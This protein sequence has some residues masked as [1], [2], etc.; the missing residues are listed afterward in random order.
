M[1]P[2]LVDECLLSAGS[3]GIKGQCFQQVR[4]TDDPG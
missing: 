1:I 3:G 2:S 4:H